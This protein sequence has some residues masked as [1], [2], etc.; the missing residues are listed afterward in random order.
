MT[1]AEKIWW[2]KI[3]AA[4]GTACLTLVLQLYIGTDGNTI[5]MFGAIIYVVISEI[6]ARVFKLDNARVLKIGIGAYFFSWI[7]IWVLLNTIFSPL[8]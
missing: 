3:A 7:M 1:P 4:W 2:L 8:I 5:F 6:M